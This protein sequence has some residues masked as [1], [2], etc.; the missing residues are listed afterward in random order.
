MLRLRKRSMT[1]ILWWFFIG[2]TLIGAI[3]TYTW[4]A[5]WKREEPKGA[6]LVYH[7]GRTRPGYI[8]ADW[9]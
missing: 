4:L 3:V 9:W 5:D 2:S 6:T 1:L 8:Q 7:S